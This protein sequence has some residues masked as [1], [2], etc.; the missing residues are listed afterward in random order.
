MNI[1]KSQSVT[2]STVRKIAY[3]DEGDLV[4]TFNTGA[5]YLYKAV[6]EEVYENMA[7]SES[8]GKFLNANIKGKFQ[9]QQLPKAQS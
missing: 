8:V 4:V 7:K 3:T 2:S 5:D 6:P 1:T 9:Y